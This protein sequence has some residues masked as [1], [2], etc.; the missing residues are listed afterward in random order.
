MR[1]KKGFVMHNIGGEYMA[2][3]TGDLLQDFYGYIRNN[4]TAAEIFRLLQE[5]TTID[6]IVDTMYE[7]YDVKK[8]TLTKDVLEMVEKLRQAGFIEE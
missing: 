7:K 8:E 3:A 6:K 1:L 5:D 4:E 2:V